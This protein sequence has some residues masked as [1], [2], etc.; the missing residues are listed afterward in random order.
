MT[1]MSYLYR[2]SIYNILKIKKNF[3]LDK[4]KIIFYKSIN[5]IGE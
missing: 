3:F 1:L 5:I 2:Y 4:K